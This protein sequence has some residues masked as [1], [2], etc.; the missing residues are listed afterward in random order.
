MV[1]LRLA[2][3]AK[4]AMVAPMGQIIIVAGPP[5]AGKTTVSN[6]LAK[7]TDADLSLCVRTDDTYGYLRKGAVPPWLPESRYQNAVLMHAMAT[8]AAV[9]ACGGYEVYV[10]GVVGPWLLEPWLNAAKSQELA[11]HYVV[12]FPDEPTTVARATARTEFGAMTD[13]GVTANMWRQFVATPPPQG[14]VLDTTGRTVDETVNAVRVGL[15]AGRF[16]VA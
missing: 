8:S 13:A 9:C 14:C 12:L 16:R 3:T 15:A 5:G 4:G 10:D 1:G 6:R 11:L 2:A 7:R